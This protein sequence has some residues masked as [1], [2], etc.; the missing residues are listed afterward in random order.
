[1]SELQI[2][3]SRGEYDVRIGVGLLDEV[4]P[5][6][7]FALVDAAVVDRLHLPAETTLSFDASEENK[8]LSGCETVLRSMQAA[9]CD[10]SSVLLAV[11]GGVV[12]DVGTLSA[13]L[14]MRGV[15]W[16]YAPTT[17]M[18]MADSC[19]GGKSSINVAGVKNLVGNI[20]PPRLVLVDLA[21]TRSLSATAIASGLAEAVKIC[22]AKGPEEFREFTRLRSAAG[23]LDSATG[24][25][26]VKHTLQCKQWFI[27]IDE[28]DGAERRLL[29]FGHT[30]GHAIESATNFAIPHGVAVALGVIAAVQHPLAEQGA[31]E[32]QLLDECREI[33]A[34]ALATVRTPLRGLDAAAFRRAFAGDKKHSSEAF[35]LILPRAGRLSEVSL[36]RTDTEIDAVLECVMKVRDEF[37]A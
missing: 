25:A 29:N 11:G 30:F 4:M 17:F 24:V 34:P 10:R 16:I 6:H 8:S 37:A 13:S 18:A 31:L 15:P 27:E 7:G 22:F 36:P 14:Y 12:Q 35:R 28:F 2:K 5:A 9:G 21:F 32:R 20:Y 23:A 19:I 26:L 3:T 33:L 1:M